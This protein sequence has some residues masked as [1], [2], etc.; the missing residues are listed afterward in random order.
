MTQGS[1]PQLLLKHVCISVSG[2]LYR[3]M[4]LALLRKDGGG[5]LYL[6][7]PHLADLQLR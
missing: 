6:A 7:D 5:S 3:A 1:R 4:E 2:D